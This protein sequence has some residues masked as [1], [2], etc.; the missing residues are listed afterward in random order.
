[1]LGDHVLWRDVADG[2][3]QMGVVVMREIAHAEPIVVFG[4][5]LP[6]S[7]RVNRERRTSGS[8]SLL[9]LCSYPPI[10]RKFHYPEEAQNSNHD[11]QKNSHETVV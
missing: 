8:V 5:L 2:S 10:C 7:Q 3:V 6:A 4:T 1:M 11:E 9:E